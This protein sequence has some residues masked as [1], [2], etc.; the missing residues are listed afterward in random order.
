LAIQ[1]VGYELTKIEGKVGSP[2]KPLS[3]LGKLGYVSY[4]ITA[5]LREL[6]PKPWP[7]KRIILPAH[8]RRK[9]KAQIQSDLYSSQHMAVLSDSNAVASSTQ[10]SMPETLSRTE[11]DRDAPKEIAFSI[12]ELAARTGIVEEDLLETLVTMGWMAHWQSPAEQGMSPAVQHSKRNHGKLVRFYEQQQLLE[13][14]AGNESLGTTGLHDTGHASHENGGQGH[15]HGS[16]SKHPSIPV[17]SMQGSP[18]LQAQAQPLSPFNTTHPQVVREED[19]I[20]LLEMPES[21]GDDGGEGGAVDVAGSALTPSGLKDVAV[22]TLEMVKDYQYRHNIRL[23]PY[24]D[25]NGIDWSA[26]RSTLDG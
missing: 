17:S 11:S 25:W 26:Y 7:A 3:D 1:H 21:E 8:G 15:H 9:S 14:F 16:S 18:S 10:E 4:W 23:D 12:R 2:E 5:I 20:A 24:V 13:K 19:P 6:Y 22:V